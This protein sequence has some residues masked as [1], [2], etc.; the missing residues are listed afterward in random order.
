MTPSA[1][2]TTAPS[3]TAT[4]AAPPPS[5]ILDHEG[6]ELPSVPPPPQWKWYQIIPTL[7]LLTVTVAGL[8][9]AGLIPRVQRQ[10][11]LAAETERVRNQRPR[12]AVT[13][14]RAEAPTTEALLPGD[15]RPMEETVI[16]ARTEG[17]VSRWTADIGEVV[18]QG[19]LL[20]ELS[21]PEIDQQLREAEAEV[22]RLRAELRRVEAE[23]K[24]AELTWRRYETLR[25][26]DATTQQELDQSLAEK[27]AAAAAVTSSEAAIRSAEAR[28]QRF[29][30]LL[31]FAH[32]T[33][34]FTGTITAR[35]VE[36]GQ[37]VTNGNENGQELYTLAR[38]DPVRVFIDVPQVY[39]SGVRIG[40]GAT[41]LVRERPDR[42]FEGTVTR[43]AGALDPATRTLRTEVQV[44]NEERLLLTGAYVQ[45][46]LEVERSA[47]RWLLPATALMFNADGTRLAIVDADS[48]VRFR[49]VDVAGEFDTEVGIA[50][51]ISEEDLVITNPG[52]HLADNMLVERVEAKTEE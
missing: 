18:T 22:T 6:E 33:A 32:I 9:L 35:S 51:G 4:P 48:R 40:A 10:E 27:D 13:H 37:L 11:A 49:D 14:P 30:Q 19:A 12:V 36:V 24:L 21:T 8:F 39:A 15:V 50:S 7:L 34:P 41:I 25:D 52:E 5:I 3:I 38:T 42:V 31:S 17:Y 16:H 44:P 46:R 2:S 20:V 1:S 45:V 28:V 29:R 47:P 26:R 43:T 23:A